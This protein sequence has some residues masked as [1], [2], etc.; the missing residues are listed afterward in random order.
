MML[1]LWLFKLMRSRWFNSFLG[2]LLLA[3]MIWSF[4]PLLAIGGVHPFDSEIVRI[5]AIAV[6][7]LLWFV[8]NLITSM[9]R[10]KRETKM[11]EEVVAAP[12]K[13]A[14]ASAEEVALLTERLKDALHQLKK[15][16]G[17]RRLRRRRL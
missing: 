11:V 17:G 6:L 3:A 1:P 4:G 15:L 2:V 8:G 16:P 13:D 5:I 10:K 9:R 12:D 14:T 7:V